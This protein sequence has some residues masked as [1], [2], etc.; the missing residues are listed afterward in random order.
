MKKYLY[1]LVPLTFGI[2]AGNSKNLS[3]D[4]YLP[5]YVI[6][7]CE[8][9]T[10]TKENPTIPV[11]KIEANY[12]EIYDLLYLLTYY[13]PNTAIRANI[14]IPNLDAGKIHIEIVNTKTLK[15]HLEEMNCDHDDAEEE[16]ITRTHNVSY[17]N[18]DISEE[19]RV[20][21]EEIAQARDILKYK[22]Y[23]SRNF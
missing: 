3:D 2:F 11:T 23:L 20:W 16:P 22:K 5:Y 7:D 8:I 12:D 1:L 18:E 14:Y 10:A 4:E 13:P 9:Y 19:V 15:E 21:R 6:R 17:E